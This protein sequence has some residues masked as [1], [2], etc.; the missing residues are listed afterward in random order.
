MRYT[1]PSRKKHM[2][3]FALALALSLIVFGCAP[4]GTSGNNAPT[5]ADAKKFIDDVNDTLLKLYVEGSQAGW[6]SET[7]ITDDTSSLNAR[8]NQRLI[9]KTAQYAKEAV[10]FDHTD[11][12]ADIRRELNLLKLSLVM[13]TPSD[14]KEGEEL[15]KIAADMDGEYGK[16]KWCEDPKKPD[17]CLDINKITDIM[18]E[19]RDEKKLRM[20]W[21]GWH[22]ISPP[23]RK[24][25]V[26]FVDLSNKGAKE[27][28]FA[29]TGAM[30]RAKYAMPPDEFTKELDRLWGQVRPLYLKL[31]A[32]VRMKLR[33][34]YG[35]I[36]PA[37][38]PLPAHLL[39]NIWA[40]DWTNV[41][42][43]VAPANADPGYNL[44]DILKRRKMSPA[45]MVKVGER[46]Y[47]SIGFAPLPKT[48]WD[49]S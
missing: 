9:D 18:R 46:F 8:A 37:N 1:L 15:T 34:K 27:L 40:Q 35:D 26:R 32:Y 47:T 23:M 33:D 6:V 45:D 2:R 29:D 44:T 25:Y 39:G 3:S 43:L 12:P 31:H 10:R 24:D 38:G 21:E 20:A 7:F 41:Y 17:T 48:F 42:P 19:S 5:A 28:G 4:S 13:A 22:T 11:V 16:G 36:V 30:W 14:P 49:R